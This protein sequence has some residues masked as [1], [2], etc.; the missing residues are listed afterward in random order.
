MHCIAAH[1]LSVNAL[2]SIVVTVV[3]CVL[4]KVWELL[5][6]HCSQTLVGHRYACL[7]GTQWLVIGHTMATRSAG[8]HPALLSPCVRVQGGGVGSGREPNRGPA[9]D[10]LL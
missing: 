9:G 4:P 7:L 3:P 10:R 1:V 8:C 2:T 6:Q 5:T